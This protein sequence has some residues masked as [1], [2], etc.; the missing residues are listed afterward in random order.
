[1]PSN[2]SG[3]GQV[4]LE[5]LLLVLDRRLRDAGLVEALERDRG[6]YSLVARTTGE[7]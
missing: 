6:I 2:L 1:L 5:R 7:E 4:E 3:C